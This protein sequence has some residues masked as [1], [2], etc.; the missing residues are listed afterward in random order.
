[1]ENKVTLINEPV[2]RDERVLRAC[3]YVRVS[4]G[5]ED[6]KNSFE[7]QRSYWKQKLTTDARYKYV[8]IYAD[9]GISGKAT[10][11]RKQFLDMVEHAK[12]GK[13]DIIFTKSVMRFGRN[14]VDILYHVR[15][16]RHNYGVVVYFEEEEMYS[17][18][19]LAD[20]ILSMRAMV[21]EQEIKDMS[22]QQKW[23]A[24][25]RFAQGSVELNGV[26]LGYN[27]VKGEDGVNRLEI[28]ESQAE[29]VRLIFSLYISGLS[30]QKIKAELERQSRL[31]AK[32]GT[33][34]PMSTI[35]RMLENE[36]YM[37]DAWLQKTYKE[38]FKKV[39]NDR[40]N[41]AVPI[42]YIENNHPPIIDR[43]TFHKV[44]RLKAE[45]TNKLKNKKITKQP[46][47]GLLTC[48][49][50]GTA[51]RHKMYQ[52]RGKA[53]YAF[54]CCHNAMTNGKGACASHTIKDSV[55]RECYIAAF[56][57]FVGIRVESDSLKA[58]QDEIKRLRE[59]DQQFYDL[60][61]KR[62]INNIDYMTE[63]KR[64]SV[65]IAEL[66]RED[67]AKSQDNLYKAFKKKM[68]EFD[69]STIDKFLKAVTVSNW[70]VTFIFKNG[71]TITKP[72]TNGTAGNKPG[73]NKIEKIK[74]ETKKHGKQ[75]KTKSG[76]LLQA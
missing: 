35:G 32:G 54:W 72:Y 63:H 7:A 16:L 11:N 31:T 73:W 50:C 19:A 29:T 65:R 60:H 52:Y 51:Y 27:L 41:P 25:R 42:V 45:R 58:I 26:I 66:E 22:E 30:I 20:T 34:W 5:S 14:F 57:E 59:Q 17:D 6:Q 62:Y 37:G 67:M 76:S 18:D 13:I 71:V 8:G 49:E 47:S 43:E 4:T 12:L 64:I 44:Q 39:Y 56:N 21:A 68:T 74:K 24:R 33:R 3:A 9:E 10:R 55:L 75:E 61:F 70:T 53:L 28:N 36:K 48:G 40:E 2:P 69:E 46:F 15:D 23:A 1:M 38:D